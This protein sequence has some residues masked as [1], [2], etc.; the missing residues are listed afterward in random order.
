MDAVID[1]NFAIDLTDK[2]T[3]DEQ[4]LS[5]MRFG[6]QTLLDDPLLLMECIVRRATKLVENQ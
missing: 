4:W 1:D 2:C 6:M 3:T 5:V